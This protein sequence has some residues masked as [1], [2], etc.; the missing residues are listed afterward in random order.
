MD[1]DGSEHGD[2]SGGVPVPAGTTVLLR[3][4]EEIDPLAF[5]GEWRSERPNLLGVTVDRSIQLFL[6]DWRATVGRKP[7]DVSLVSV[8]EATRSAT[9]SAS[10]GGCSGGDQVRT[11]ADP[12]DLD[13]VER[14]IESLLDDWRPRP[15]PTV[16]VV[17]TVTGLLDV[18][19]ERD[20]AAFAA[21]LA[22]LVADADAF[23][24]LATH[25]SADVPAS[26]ERT[27]DDA[28]EA[29]PDGWRPAG[30]DADRRGRLPPGDSFALLARG[31]RRRLL[32]ALADR[33]RATVE[34][35]AAAIADGT[36]AEHTRL[37]GSLVHVHLPKLD[38]AGVVVYDAD[39][40]VVEPT[41]EVER[42][43]AVV[44]LADSREEA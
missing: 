10:A 42:L 19:P 8:G 25:G 7:G 3:P 33:D 4:G 32:S 29:T 26:L 27:C 20:V 1:S 24:F 35:L 41:D 23:G 12:T 31:R 43:L 36:D 38:D 11:V 39:A 18:A 9:D 37:A 21:D 17:D 28:I 5:L 13:A 6:A 16:I 40:S 2:G 14:Q 34:E 22:D 44:E 30:S 15:E